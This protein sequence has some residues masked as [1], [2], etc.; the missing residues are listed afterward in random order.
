MAW[1][2]SQFNTELGRVLDDTDSNNPAHGTDL[3]VDALNAALRAFVSHKPL[4]KSGS[5]SDAET[6]SVPS[7]C[8]RIAAVVA[9]DDDGVSTALSAASIGNPGDVFDANSYWVWGTTIYLGDEYPSV[10]LYYYAY[11]PIATNATTDIIVPEWARD[12]IVYLS[13]AHCLMPNLSS[14]ARLGAFND[15]QDAAPLQNSLIQAANWFVE[16]FE[17]IVATHR[18][19]AG[20]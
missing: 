3:R 15:R 11:Y 19:V 2:W 16:Q 7:D 6:I 17:R 5:S 18:Q 10:T 1:S 4:Q 9:T 12:A 14:R 13:A 8:Y 20:L